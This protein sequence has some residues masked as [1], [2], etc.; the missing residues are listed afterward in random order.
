MTGSVCVSTDFYLNFS[1]AI[2]TCQCELI[3]CFRIILEVL[4]V[5]QKNS[6]YILGVK[7][8]LDHTH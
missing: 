7:T 8:N 1:I 4:G 2:K 3:L 6:W 5:L